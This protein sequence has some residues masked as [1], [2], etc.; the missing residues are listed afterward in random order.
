MTELRDISPA[1]LHIGD[2]IRTGAR[3]PRDLVASVR[4][5]GVLLPIRAYDDEEGRVVVIDGQLRTLA[6]REAGLDAVPVMV[7]NTPSD[8]DR[9]VDQWVA[10]ERREALS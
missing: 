10:N 4:A 3:A 6:A 2:N 5:R 1:D 9:L 8:A 7:T